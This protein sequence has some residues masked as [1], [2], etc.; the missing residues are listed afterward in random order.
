[1]AVM[2]LVQT[3]FFENPNVFNRL[4]FARSGVKARLG[5]EATALSCNISSPS[6]IVGFKRSQWILIER[7]DV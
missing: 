1:M 6:P 5:V 2:R 3:E 4:I 7:I